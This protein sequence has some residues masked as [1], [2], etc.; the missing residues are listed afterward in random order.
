MKTLLTRFFKPPKT[1]LV[2]IAESTEI[3]QSSSFIEEFQIEINSFFQRPSE[4]KGLLEPLS[5]ASI[6]RF[7]DEILYNAMELQM[8]LTKQSLLTEEQSHKDF[9]TAVSWHIADSIVDIPYKKSERSSG[10]EEKNTK[11]NQIVFIKY[12]LSFQKAFEEILQTYN[13]FPEPLQFHSYKDYL[14]SINSLSLKP[15]A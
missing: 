11:E 15:I 12:F 7:L 1:S 5:E 10:L 13:G 4:L 9:V 8:K 14:E 6:E 2:E 3:S